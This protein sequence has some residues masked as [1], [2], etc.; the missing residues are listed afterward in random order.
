MTRSAATSPPHPEWGPRNV[1]G[2]CLL[3]EDL[4]CRKAGG[5]GGRELRLWAQVPIGCHIVEVNDC[6]RGRLQRGTPASTADLACSVHREVHHHEIETSSGS[7]RVS[8][9]S[10]DGVEWLQFI[11]PKEA[12]DT[13]QHFL[14]KAEQ[15]TVLLPSSALQSFLLGFVAENFVQSLRWHQRVCSGRERRPFVVQLMRL[16]SLAAASNTGT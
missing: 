12:D 2:F 15:G 9:A 6:R 1:V 4:L 7:Y 10:A 14:R 8:E 16:N 11:V 3:T 13:G 5:I